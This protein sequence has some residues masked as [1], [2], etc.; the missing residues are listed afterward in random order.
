[1]PPLRIR[2]PV[3]PRSPPMPSRPHV[4]Q[5]GPQRRRVPASKEQFTMTYPGIFAALARE[6]SAT[7]LAEA[8]A[9]RWTVERRAR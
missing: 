4:P 1:L 9:A 8:E 7:V 3:N 2:N 5:I 6:R